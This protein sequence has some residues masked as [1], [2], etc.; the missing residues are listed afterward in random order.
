MEQVTCPTCRGAG[1]TQI[2][3]SERVPSATGEPQS[4]KVCLTCLGTGTVPVHA[5]IADLQAQVARL[6]EALG[7]AEAVY[8]HR[9]VCEECTSG[10]GCAEFYTLHARAVAIRAAP[11]PQEE[12]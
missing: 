9:H 8:L 6:T 4:Y 7:A 11:E 5:E 10:R 2:G 1:K 12:D 3:D